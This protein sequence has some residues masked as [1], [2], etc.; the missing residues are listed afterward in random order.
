MKIKFVEPGTYKVARQIVETDG[1]KIF[2]IFS[3]ADV[4]R[5]TEGV[6]YEVVVEL[7]MIEPDPAPNQ[8][9]P[10]ET[11]EP[12][13]A[14]P[15]APEPPASPPEPPDAEPVASEPKQKVGKGS[16]GK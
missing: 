8:T 14:E 12:P 3:E 13:A 7:Q 15:V 10:T 11:P 4:Q 2:E 6:H 16:G 5:Y 1:T 9:E